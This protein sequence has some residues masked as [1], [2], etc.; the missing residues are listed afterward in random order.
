MADPCSRAR[1][2]CEVCIDH[3]IGQIAHTTVRCA[4]RH[5]GDVIGVSHVG[6]SN[7]SRIQLSRVFR[8]ERTVTVREGDALVTF[9]SGHIATVVSSR[10]CE[11][12][13]DEEV[14][15]QFD[16][17][18]RVGVAHLNIGIAIVAHRPSWLTIEVRGHLNAGLRRRVP[19]L[20]TE[21]ALIDVRE[22]GG[23][24]HVQLRS[25]RVQDRDGLGL[26]VAV[27]GTVNRGPSALKRVAVWAS[28]VG[29][30]LSIVSGTRCTVT[31]VTCTQ[32][33]DCGQSWNSVTLNVHHIS[34]EQCEF[35]SRRVID[36]DLLNV[37]REI[38]VAIVYAV[39]TANDI[40]LIA[41]CRENHV[42]IGHRDNSITVVHRLSVE[43]IAWGVLRNS[44]T[45]HI[46]SE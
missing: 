38:L 4:D 43:S 31:V 18:I 21:E 16:N 9:L 32:A 10:H 46:T 8:H 36:G 44:V 19:I 15:K 45:I 3:F 34:G 11:R 27:S 6:T 1:T 39:S 24:R 41:S 33:G 22:F 30:N 17:V 29:A 26:R 23:T 13:R 12:P 5:E 28:T 7:R 20:S 37:L 25:L 42:F 40:L 14:T 2:R 35:R